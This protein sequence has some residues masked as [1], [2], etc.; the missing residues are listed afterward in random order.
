MDALRTL[1][2]EVEVLTRERLAGAHFPL[3]IREDDVVHL[4]SLS[5]A[6]LALELTRRHQLPLLYTAHSVVE[7]E[8]GAT[9]WSALQQRVFDEA[10]HV[11]FVSHAEHALL[12]SIGDR[13]HVL[14]NGV[15]APPSRHDYDEHGPIVF[16]GRFTRTKGFDRVLDLV[17]S[18]PFEFVLAGGHGDREL[19]ERASAL[20]SPRCR[21]AGWIAQNAIERLFA[22]A[23]LVVMPSRYEP[24]GMVA[25]EAMRA[26]A[27]LLASNTGG[28]AEIVTPES[29]GRIVDDDAWRDACAQLLADPQAR[30]AMHAR[31]P[32]YVAEHFDSRRLAA[33]LLPLLHTAAA[34]RRCST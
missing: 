29:G 30:R 33:E 31:G 9:S 14:H 16:A 28:L 4:H 27:P 11:I 3:A 7:H 1:G 8:V 12:P 2:V 21:L 26:G 6:E 19:H 22:A 20:A 5:L 23:S 13:A 25:I 15:P 18:T 17:E 10:A 24:F 34:C 32:R